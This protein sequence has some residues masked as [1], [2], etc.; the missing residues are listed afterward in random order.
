MLAASLVN[1]ANGW[2]AI[3]ASLSTAQPLPLQLAAIAGVGL[4]G[5]TLVAALVGLALGAVP[6]RLVDMRTPAGP[7]RDPAGYCGRTRGGRC[8]RHRHLVAHAAMG[9]ASRHRGT[10]HR[11]PIRRG[12]YGSDCRLPDATR[13]SARDVRRHRSPHERLDPLAHTRRDR[14][15]RS[16]AS[17][18]PA[19]RPAQQCPGWL[20][21]GALTGA[22][23]VIGYVTLLRIDLSMTPL[24]LGSAAIAGRIG[25]RRAA[26]FPGRAARLADR[27]NSDGWRGV[28]LVPCPSKTA[29]E[30]LGR[31]ATAGC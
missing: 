23:L 30:C 2:P 6:R 3:M 7:G 31:L 20:T 15:C 27:W 16:S 9:T 11:H 5:L 8:R 1:A 21:A 13:G 29:P 24:V 12:R 22:A 26:A 25:A 14:T 10:E 28:A 4:V 19:R 17:S 18:P